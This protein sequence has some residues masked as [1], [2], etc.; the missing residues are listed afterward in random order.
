MVVLAGRCGFPYVCELFYT[1]PSKCRMLVIYWKGDIYSCIHR[2]RIYETPGDVASTGVV[3]IPPDTNNL[4]TFLG[5]KLLFLNN[6]FYKDNTSDVY[7]T[8]L[9]FKETV[10]DVPQP[11]GKMC[12][13]FSRK[14]LVTLRDS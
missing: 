12:C 13:W 2:C 1:F 5:W 11:D 6:F 3:T 10:T 4:Y 8:T 9:G 7:C 14:I